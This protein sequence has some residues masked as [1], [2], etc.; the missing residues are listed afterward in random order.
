MRFADFQLASHILTFL[1]FG[2]P[3]KAVLDYVTYARAYNSDHQLALLNQVSYALRNSLVLLSRVS[4]SKEFLQINDPGSGDDV[5]VSVCSGR[6][7][8]C[9][10]S[11]QVVTSTLTL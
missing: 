11:L 6:G 4:S 1:R 3:G 5:R 9:Y 10:R 2:L 8:Q 7:G